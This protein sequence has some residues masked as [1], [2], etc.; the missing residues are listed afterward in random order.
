VYGLGGFVPP[1]LTLLRLP[2]SEASFN[3]KHNPEPIIMYEITLLFFNISIFT[4][5]LQWYVSKWRMCQSIYINKGSKNMSK[6]SPKVFKDHPDIMI[7]E[8]LQV[9]GW[10]DASWVND[11]LPCSELKLPCGAGFRVWVGYDAESTPKQKHT[12][13]YCLE[14]MTSMELQT[15]PEVVYQGDDMMTMLY[16]MTMRRLKHLTEILLG[17]E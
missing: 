12:H 8:F 4:F 15:T 10:E 7:P 14:F 5:R 17:M 9:G 2:V 16:A 6:K 11:E 13:K 3:T 1:G